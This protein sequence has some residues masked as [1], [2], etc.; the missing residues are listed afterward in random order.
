MIFVGNFMRTMASQAVSL[1]LLL[2]S[3]FFRLNVMSGIM[4]KATAAK[5]QCWRNQWFMSARLSSEQCGNASGE[6]WKTRMSR[7]R[8][9]HLCGGISVLYIFSP[10]FLR[11]FLSRKEKNN[12]M[13]QCGNMFPTECGNEDVIYVDAQVSFA[14]AFVVLS[15]HYY[16][17]SNKQE[18]IKERI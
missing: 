5:A 3:S 1:L 13:W 9:G 10:L 16:C 8:S 11:L 4:W 12:L 7:G 14:A 2:S 18:R 6:M 15:F 17:E